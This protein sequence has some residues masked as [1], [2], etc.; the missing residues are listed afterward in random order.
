MPSKMSVT[1]PALRADRWETVLVELVLP[2]T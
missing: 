2:R 1:T